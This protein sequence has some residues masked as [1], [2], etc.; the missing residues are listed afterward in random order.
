MLE[1]VSSPTD[2]DAAAHTRQHGRVAGPTDTQ[3]V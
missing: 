3:N 1:V 2:T